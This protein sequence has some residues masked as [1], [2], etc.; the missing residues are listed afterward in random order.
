MLLLV[1][2]QNTKTNHIAPITVQV[3]QKATTDK[4]DIQSIPLKGYIVYD[5]GD[6]HPGLCGG[7]S[8]RMSGMFSAYVISVMLRKHFL[9]R[10]TRSSNLTDYL[11]PNS[12]DW[13]Y[14]SAILANRSWGYQNFVSETPDA[15]KK[16]DLTGLDTLFSKDVNFVRINWD[17]TE[18]FRKFPGL[19]KVIP[20]LLELHF[21]DIYLKFFNT[22]FKPTNMITKA[23][24]K[25][26]QNVTK[27]ACAH[28]RI[29]RSDTIKIDAKHTDEKQLIHIWNL[30][31]TM[32]AS[33]YSIFIA[34]DAE[35]VQRRAR[36]LFKHLLET[37]GRVLHIDRSAEGDG[38]VGGYKKVVVDFFVLT[39]CDVLVLTLSG[40]GIMSSYLNTKVSQLYCLTPHE[41]VPCSRY[42]VHNVIPGQVLSPV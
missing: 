5:C 15:I 37:E 7:W 41:L 22:L 20:W 2:Y 16:Q 26:V 30:L 8:D 10:Y 11:A 39:K 28:I 34:T 24:N 6:Q 42:T 1:G 9:I 29:G 12:F 3:H 18:H 23:V 35:F 21:S 25:V 38:V 17:Y 31:K 36:T 19:Q 4:K 13:K 27:L 14:N 33:N 40:F 32:E